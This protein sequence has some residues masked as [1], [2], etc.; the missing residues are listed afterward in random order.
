MALSDFWY[1]VLFSEEL[2]RGHVK[3]VEL[4]GMPLAVYRTSDDAVHAVEDACAHRSARLSLGRV[5]GAAV[6]CPYH[7]WRFDGSGQCV[8]IPTL[9]PDERIPKA[10]TVRGYAA[11]E[12]G[13]LV[14]VFG[15]GTSPTQDEPEMFDFERNYA[16]SPEWRH[17]QFARTLAFDHALLIENLMDPAHVHFVH[18]GSISSPSHAR[19]YDIDIERDEWGFRSLRSGGGGV[20]SR[21]QVPCGATLYFNFG[22]PAFMQVHIA[23][24]VPI[25]RRT[26]R[27]LY[28]IYMRGGMVASLGG[29]PM[30]KS[31]QKILDQD[32]A[33]LEGLQKQLDAGYPPYRVP[34]REDAAILAYRKWLERVDDEPSA[35]P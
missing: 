4:L 29:A 34:V 15:G 31:A 9:K 20:T 28:R 13:G 14:W 7:G 35:R 11:C 17:T 2:E 1:P 3:R 22:P 25:D 27:L 21:F 33:L 5:R 8:G 19:P 30:A 23:Y 12:R 18:E 24:C 16:D 26:T 10:A 32:I 6:E